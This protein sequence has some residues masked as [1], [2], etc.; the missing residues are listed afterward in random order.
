MG[1]APEMNAAFAAC[2]RY[3]YTYRK[4][5]Y[6]RHNFGL[7]IGTRECRSEAVLTGGLLNKPLGAHFGGDTR[8]N[9]LSPGLSCLK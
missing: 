3:T 7:Q 6:A 2:T 4:H 8:A 1:E 5:A 9:F